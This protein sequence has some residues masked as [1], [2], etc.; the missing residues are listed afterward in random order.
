MPDEKRVTIQGRITDEGVECLA[1]RAS[2]GK[3][4]YTLVGNLHGAAPGDPV[5]VT[6]RVVAASYC[7]QGTTIE[8][9]AL[10]FLGR[11]GV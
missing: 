7:M 3:K 6:G 4:L 2:E 8:V 10:R 1:M 5:E 11:K 9:D